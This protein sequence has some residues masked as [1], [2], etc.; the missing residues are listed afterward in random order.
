M[1][2]MRIRRASHTLKLREFGA[3]SIVSGLAGMGQFLSHLGQHF[4][5]LAR[6]G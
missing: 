5:G 4:S 3:L 2:R 1:T 6:I